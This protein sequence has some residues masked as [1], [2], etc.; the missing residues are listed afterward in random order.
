[1]KALSVKQ[2]FAEAIARGTK[3]REFRSR[4]IAYRGPIIIVASKSP[5][6]GSLPTGVTVCTV[7]IV[8]CEGSGS[9]FSW[10]L[11]NPARVDPVAVRGNAWI[12]TV[13][14]ALIVPMRDE[15]SYS[16]ASVE[17][18][19][20]EGEGEGDERRKRRREGVAATRKLE[21]LFARPKVFF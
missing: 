17:E 10:V 16:R 20:D 13:P 8:A 3:T 21:A 9:R 11:R 12:Y 5:K 2:P 7:E 6:L 19:D 1:M 15:P 4:P 18:G 14:D